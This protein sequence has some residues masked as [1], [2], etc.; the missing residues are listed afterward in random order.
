[1]NDEVA[2]F[3]LEVNKYTDLTDDEFE[4]SFTGLRTPPHKA[5]SAHK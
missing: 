4:N 3:T 2:P 5:K 1:L